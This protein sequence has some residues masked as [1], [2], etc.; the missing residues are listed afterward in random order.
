[1]DQYLDIRVLPDPEFDR[2][3]LLGA[4]VSKLHRG[5]VAIN[6]DDIG[7]SFPK[8]SEKPRGLGDRLRIH[9]SRQRLSELMENDWLHGMK[10]H[11]HISEISDVPKDAIY[12]IVSRRQYKTS[13]DRLRRRRMK[14]KHESWE[15][16]VDK[17]PDC[18]ER[19]VKTPFI[20]VRS[21]STGNAFSL[22][23][24]HGDLLP[25]PR[26]GKFS[27]YGLSQD[28]TIPWF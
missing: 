27:S 16:A 2:N 3:V 21:A 11:I 23:I 24:E 14:R 6:A 5:L 18:V 25:E 12:R 1:M 13:A 9:A 22:F 17:I 10:D 19:K 7:I 28:A 26:E 15:E 4:L 8:Q 20:V